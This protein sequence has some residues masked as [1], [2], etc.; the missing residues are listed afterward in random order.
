[1]S[2]HRTGVND[3]DCRRIVVEDRRCGATLKVNIYGN[4]ITTKYRV[5]NC[6]VPRPPQGSES[7]LGGASRE[8][9]VLSQKTPFPFVG[10]AQTDIRGSQRFEM[11]EQ[12]GF[13]I[14]ILQYVGTVESRKKI[15]LRFGWPRNHNSCGSD[16]SGCH[17]LA[18]S[19]VVAINSPIVEAVLS[20]IRKSA[21]L[22]GHPRRARWFFQSHRRCPPAW[23]AQMVAQTRNART[24]WSGG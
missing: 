9:I 12:R 11:P 22:L 15:V 13:V 18:I 23:S 8:T 1:M 24:R 4:S 17:V 16:T 2:I 14:V 7:S 19:R 3:P 10:R 20:I 6:E 5:A 21:A